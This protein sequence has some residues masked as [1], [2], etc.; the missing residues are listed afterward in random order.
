MSRFTELL[1]LAIDVEKLCREHNKPNRLTAEAFT[2]EALTYASTTPAKLE[3]LK[4]ALEADREKFEKS[5]A[6]LNFI[7]KQIREGSIP[8]TNGLKPMHLRW[9]ALG[10]LDSVTL[11]LGP[12]LSNPSELFALAVTIAVEK[13]PDAFGEIKNWKTHLQKQKDS[14]SLRSKLFEQIAQS[15]TSEDLL[16]GRVDGQ[17]RALI[18]F[19]IGGGAV[20]LAPINNAGERLVNHLVDN[21]EIMAEPVIRTKRTAKRKE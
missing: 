9:F 14:Q 10:D 15:Y 6:F 11:E 20:P 1:K 21:P 18:T 12:L 4:Q 13:Y 2:L 19:K 3:K 5:W 16:I 17:G 7:V 8:S